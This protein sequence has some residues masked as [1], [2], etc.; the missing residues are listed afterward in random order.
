M[1]A[2]FKRL[3]DSK[4]TSRMTEEILTN[5]FNQFGLKDV[6]IQRLIDV[7][8]T[9]SNRWQIRTNYIDNDTSNKLTDALDNAAKPLSLQLDRSTLHI[10]TV[11]PTMG[12][13]A[14]RAALIATLVA[15]IAALLCV[16]YA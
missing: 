5:V 9:S 4:Q 14:T 13:E 8:G 3:P 2:E 7:S 6:R 16:V 15:S 1:R 11:T 10:N 12:S